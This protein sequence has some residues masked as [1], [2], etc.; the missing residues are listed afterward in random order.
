M[1][2]HTYIRTGDYH[3]GTMANA[4]AVEVDSTYVSAC[5]AAGVY[6][7][8]YYPHNFHF[9]AACAA[10]EGNSQTAIDASWRMVEKLD[11]VAMRQS[12]Y[13]T[14]QHYYTI[15]YYVM[16][17][18][19]RW[20]DILQL[21]RPAR[22]LYYPTAIWRYARG[23]AFVGTGQLE[24]AAHELIN[25]QLLQ[26]EE[27]VRNFTIWDINKVGDLLDIAAW[28]LEGE[29]AAARGDLEKAAHLLGKAV[30]VEDQLN[31][32]EPP[33][34]FFSVRHHLGPVLMKMEQYEEAEAL[35]RR[36]LELFPKNGYALHGLY[37]ALIKQSRLQEAKDILH[38]LERAWKNADVSL[39]NSRV[40][41]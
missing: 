9:L 31:Y 36:D 20:K 13:E 26:R 34:W 28:V 12:G 1:P 19:A 27:S 4:R 24:R 17:K 21:P 11:T 16:V 18:F 41:P 3:E 10:F 32:N 15:P 2:S 40:L 22:D 33:D 8:A 6:P 29:L 30:A 35:F 25:L 7:L 37:E 14:I 38:R 39:E 5:H 23:M